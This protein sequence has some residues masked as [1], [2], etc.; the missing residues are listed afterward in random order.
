MIQTTINP[1]SSGTSLLLGTQFASGLD[2]IIL[3]MPTANPTIDQLITA[4]Y[5]YI[6][7]NYI[8]PGAYLGGVIPLA[9]QVEL[10][11]MI[12]YSVNQ[13][14]NS[15][16]NNCGYSS[17]QMKLI[18]YLLRGIY[19]VPVASMADFI[20]DVEDNITQS[21][22]TTQQ[23]APLFFATAIGQALGAAGQY[24]YW[25]YQVNQT[26]GVPGATNWG[27]YFKD[28]TNPGAPGGQGNAAFNRENVQAWTAAG[29]EGAL[30]MG[31]KSMSYGL[32]DPGPNNMAT[33]L[34][35]VSALA[36]A[37]A[38]A[39]GKVIFRWIPRYSG[40]G[41]CGCH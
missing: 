31:N 12:G 22:L 39:A 10:K 34:D 11:S 3:A 19:S 30:L 1:Y 8:I 32:L 25:A 38:V 13:Y 36:G 26:F 37:L 23:Q 15:A 4:V 33:G 9:T 27:V 14:I 2:S 17:A 18:D 20:A 21:N 35:I 16:I 28:T 29:M 40:D 7:G 24:P 6:T 5:T 41:N